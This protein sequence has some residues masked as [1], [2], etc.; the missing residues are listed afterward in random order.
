MKKEVTLT[1]LMPCLNEEST[2][3]KCVKD[4]IDFIKK[5]KINGEVLIVDNNST[6]NSSSIAKNAGARVI[7]ESRKGYGSALKKGINEAYGKYI[8]M[9]D[10]D[11]SYDLNDLI[12]LYK[13]LEEGY[14]FVI[15]NRFN[16]TI[17]KGAMPF[18]NKYLGNP[19]L[20]FMGRVLYS[21]HIIKDYHCGLRGFNKEKM[22]ELNLESNGMELA[23]EMVIKVIKNK[24]KV[25]E[26]PTN[27]YK[28][29]REGKSHLRPVRDGLRHIKC[30]IKYKYRR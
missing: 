7:K 5:N 19:V 9:F 17:E 13:K 29:G 28:D 4:S 21:N 2:V 30:M 3:G 8:I 16:G 10:S 27:L 14:D 22:I 24:L 26:V 12:V 6:D 20:S 18:F 23:S 25:I 11:C 1:I 15:G